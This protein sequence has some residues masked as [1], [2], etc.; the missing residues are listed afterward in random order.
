M[1]F[2]LGIT[3]SFFLSTPP[4]A[5][6]KADRVQY[7]Y[8]NDSDLEDCDEDVTDPHPTA[9]ARVTPEAHVAESKSEHLNHVPIAQEAAV[10]M[11]GEQQERVHLG[12]EGK[13]FRLRLFIPSS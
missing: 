11:R 13:L 10:E 2:I 12:E 5:T 3:P 9:P 1:H 4:R 8:N 7:G 6:R